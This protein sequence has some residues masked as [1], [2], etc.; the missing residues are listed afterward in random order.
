[1]KMQ[2]RA[3]ERN[4]PSC[5]PFNT[6]V[7][8]SGYSTFV[9]NFQEMSRFSNGGVPFLISGESASP[10]RKTD[11]GT[12]SEENEKKIEKASAKHSEKED[13][14]GSDEPA[15]KK[16]KHQ[17]T[18]YSDPRHADDER[19]KYWERRRRNNASAKKSRDARRARELQTQ[20]KLAFLEKENMRMLAELMAVRQENVC[21]RRVLSKH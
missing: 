20:I 18:E 21:L 2:R 6:Y 8:D 10:H 11:L 7:F 19:K 5:V 4:P 9:N 3:S 15:Q 16:R 17:D 14:F 1:M 13:E 12:I